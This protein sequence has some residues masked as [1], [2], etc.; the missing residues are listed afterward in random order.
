MTPREWPAWAWALATLAATAFGYELTLGRY[1]LGTGIALLAGS[2]LGSRRGAYSQVLAAGPALLLT[3]TGLIGSSVEW[4]YIVGHIAA[5][6]MAGW[7]APADKPLQHPR[8]VW[9]T[10]VVMLAA[11]VPAAMAWQEPWAGLQLRTYYNSVLV[12]ALVIAF[13][14]A[15]RLVRHPMRV[16]GFM[17][18]LA[19]FYILGL[20][21]VL[22][23][24][25][26]QG[27]SVAGAETWGNLVFH[28]YVAHLPADVLSGVV[29]A[30]FS[31]PRTS[32]RRHD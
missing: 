6:A 21:W 2:F 30:F 22:I 4:G 12:M 25:R 9:R 31:G 14:Y 17:V 29:V 5:A 28:G 24:E 3:G 32:R 18:A 15:M 16:L 10:A 19:P 7:L 23:L 27:E 26:L 1:S 13:Y 11:A 8:W 20:D